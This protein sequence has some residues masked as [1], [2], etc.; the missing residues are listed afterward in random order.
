MLDH[1]GLIFLIAI[2][3]NKTH[4]Y[5]AKR[6]ENFEFYE[7][8]CQSLLSL[9]LLTNCSPILKEQ[10]KD[11]FYHC[12][13]LSSSLLLARLIFLTYLCVV[14]T[15]THTIFELPVSGSHKE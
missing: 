10:E 11:Y 8:G 4:I 7:N 9:A 5:L 12:M 3:M 2:G 1:E 14:R 15:M 13:V 6:E